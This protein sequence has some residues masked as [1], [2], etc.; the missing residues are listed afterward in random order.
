MTFAHT[1]TSSGES[2]AQVT[3]TTMLSKE[4][5]PMAL[6]FSSRAQKCSKL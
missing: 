4:S 6:S 5:A 2:S 3:R 1:L